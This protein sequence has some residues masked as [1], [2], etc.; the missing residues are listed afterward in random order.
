MLGESQI[1]AIFTGL[2]VYATKF[3]MKINGTNNR[4]RQIR[5]TMGEMIFYRFVNKG[6][7]E[8]ESI[9]FEAAILI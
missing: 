9:S 3:K 1:F 2:K 8:R 4:S 6:E 7:F 5:L